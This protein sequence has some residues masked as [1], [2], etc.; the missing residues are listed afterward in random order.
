VSLRWIFIARRPPR[1]MTIALPE[2]AWPAPW[3]ASRRRT[4]P[5][6]WAEMLRWRPS[7]G[8]DRRAGRAGRGALRPR[9][10]PPPA[11]A[12]LLAMMCSN[13]TVTP[14][15]PS[16]AVN[17]RALTTLIHP[18]GKAPRRD[19]R[20]VIDRLPTDSD[21]GRERGAEPGQIPCASP[22]GRD[23]E[24]W[25]AVSGEVHP[26]GALEDA[27]VWQRNPFD[28]AVCV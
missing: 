7:G 8:P 24:I 20:V 13:M 14:K 25:E 1:L 3:I 22:V 12:R 19:Q 28:D 4:P 26:T 10:A 21:L 23:G 9:P 16:A 6:T 5:N 17:I 18:A 11:T 27:A 2:R 15:V